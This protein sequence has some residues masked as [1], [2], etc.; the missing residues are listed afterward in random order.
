MIVNLYMYQLS[1]SNV[2]K[3][4]CRASAAVMPG[5]AGDN[6]LRILHVLPQ[7]QKKYVLDH[8]HLPTFW[9]SCL[10]CL[11]EA[12]NP[13]NMQQTFVPVQNAT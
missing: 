3:G 8:A 9:P 13:Q 2:K 6:K 4:A 11:P 7:C 1:W 12:A 10:R 5:L